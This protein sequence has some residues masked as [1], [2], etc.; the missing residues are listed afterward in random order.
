MIVGLRM[1]TGL[2]IGMDIGATEGINGL[3]RIANHQQ[4]E[5]IFCIVFALLLKRVAVL[6]D[7]REDRKLQR[8]GILEFINKRDG[9]TCC[10]GFGQGFIIGV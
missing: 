10:H 1:M 9:E 5:L 7:A 3:L 2:N 4:A 8:I 6:V